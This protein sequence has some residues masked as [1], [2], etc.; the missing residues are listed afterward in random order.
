MLRFSLHALEKMRLRK[1]KKLYVY[2]TLK[3]PDEV[4]EDVEHGVMIA[5]R[6]ANAKSVVLAY[7]VGVKQLRLFCISS[8]F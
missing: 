2:E 5:V 6:K 4:Y 3:L 8:L 1:V 7:K